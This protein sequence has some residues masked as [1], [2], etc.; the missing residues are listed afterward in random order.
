MGPARALP[1]AARTW[2]IAM[3]DPSRTSLS[4]YKALLAGL[5]PLSIYASR[6]QKLR[7]RRDAMIYLIHRQGFSHH[8]IAQAFAVS[9]TL[10]RSVVYKVAAYDETRGNGP[11]R[12]PY[13]VFGPEKVFA[14]IVNPSA[15]RRAQRD[16]TIRLAHRNGFSQ[17]SLAEAFKL[18]R[19]RIAVI[20]Q[21]DRADPPPGISVVR[22]HR[23]SRR[24]PE[25]I[26]GP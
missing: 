20:I 8:F 17:R 23:P 10:V 2:D 18:P 21:S 5:P 3:V 15:R 22:G 26:P 6:V 16:L 19:S 11:R 9:R 24:R 7:F 13:A 25:R 12:L 1:P 14:K 4:E